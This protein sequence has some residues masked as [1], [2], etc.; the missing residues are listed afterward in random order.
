MYEIFGEFIGSPSAREGGAPVRRLVV[1][2]ALTIIFGIAFQMDS[3]VAYGQDL[4]GEPAEGSAQN[5]DALTVQ[6][7]GLDS[8]TASSEDPDSALVQS[9]PLP[10]PV[11][12][13]PPT[14]EA[15]TGISPDGLTVQADSLS[16]L[17]N[18]DLVERQV[19]EQTWQEVENSGQAIARPRTLA[20]AEANLSFAQERLASARAA[21]GKMIRRDY[22]TGQPRV[23]IY[24]EERVAEKQVA[25]A[26][27]W[28]R[29]LGGS[30]D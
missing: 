12:S 17:P 6:S 4:L 15:Q 3:A 18:A 22:P 7:Q 30:T 13:E 1:L 25:Q 8:H 20:E 19:D 14:P 24:D 26:E 27:G 28:V 10:A 23:R 11:Q 29:E 5:P 9:H 16:T 2:A 21:V